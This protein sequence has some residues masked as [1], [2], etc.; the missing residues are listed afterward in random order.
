MTSVYGRAMPSARPGR[1][2]LRRDESGSGGAPRVS[3][4]SLARGRGR[5]G[6][7]RR[8]RAAL[9]RSAGDRGIGA[10]LGRRA[11][12]PPTPTG[13]RSARGSG[14]WGS[15][16]PGLACPSRACSGVSASS[17]W[18]SPARNRAHPERLRSVSMG[19][20]RR[21]R[22]RPRNQRDEAA[23]RGGAAARLQTGVTR[24]AQ[25]GRAR[26]RRMHRVRAQGAG[27]AGRTTS[28]AVPTPLIGRSHASIGSSTARRSARH[29]PM[30]HASTRARAN[31]RS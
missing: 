30:R 3:R 7:A 29:T 17:T 31:S 23:A 12:G 11:V 26:K 22:S 24:P 25:P 16:A 1:A 8:R 10:R 14:L 27:F 15:R 9:A 5:P 21:C 6:A 19:R 13:R 18:P 20:P 2:G 28:R 4:R